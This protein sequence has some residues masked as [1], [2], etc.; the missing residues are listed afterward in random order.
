MENITRR[1][2]LR[3]LFGGL[4]LL[5]LPRLSHAETARPYTRI[6][7][8]GDPHLAVRIHQHPKKADQD[9][10][11]AAKRAVIRDIN[12]WDDVDAVAVV[13][14]IVEQ[15]G[16]PEEYRFIKDFFA[17]LHAPLWVV[18]GNHEFLYEDKRKPDGGAKTASPASWKKKLA[19][20]AQF[21]HLSSRYYT[22]NIAGYHLIFLSAEGPLPVEIGEEQLAWFED[23][24]SRHPETTLV[25]FHGPLKG[26]LLNYNKSVNTPRGCAQPEGRLQAILSRNPQVRLW[27]SGHTHTPATNYSYAA[28]GINRY[29]DTLV[30]IHNADMDRK[31]I[32]T[33]SLYLYPDHI[34]V[35]T[36][37][38]HAHAWI[39]QFDRRYE[40]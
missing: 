39:P 18:N 37:D 31:K 17:P 19:R 26:T 34:E 9:A 13:G 38:H 35:K 20:Y 29:S 33:N 8:L 5:G 6:V 27:V 7:V 14:D 16:V 23:D 3:G 15:R 32:W 28:D 25:F 21:W 1:N 22:K 12:A 40:R 36:Y 30:D 10:I 11:V 4:V 2:F 24:L